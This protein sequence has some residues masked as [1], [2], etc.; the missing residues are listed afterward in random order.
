[1]VKRTGIAVAN[2]VVCMDN[3]LR[4]ANVHYMT[5]M[6][7]HPLNGLISFVQERKCRVH[8]RQLGGHRLA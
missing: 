5:L 7:G 2:A 8:M 1:M 4:D 3:L 6:G